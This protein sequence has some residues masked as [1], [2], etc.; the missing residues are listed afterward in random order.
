VLY[1]NWDNAQLFRS[2][3]NNQWVL[4]LGSQYSLGNYRLRSGYAYAQ[5]PID[6]T[7]INNI[8]GVFPPGGPPSVRYTQGLLAVTP[9]HRISMGIGAVDVL[10]GIDMDLLVGGMFR[11]T[12]Q[13]GPSTTTSMSSYWIG[14]G[15]TWRFG[16]CPTG[17]TMSP[18]E[19][20]GFSTQ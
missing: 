17:C 7:P 10:P 14:F 3:Y 18:S 15:L 1:K 20:T 11:D 19:V 5:N 9:Q 8:G 13:L 6:P 2:V 16:A 12:E 4:Q